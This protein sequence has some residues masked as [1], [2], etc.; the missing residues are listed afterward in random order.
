M[1][2]RAFRPSTLSERKEFYEKEFDIERL[3]KWFFENGMKLPQICALDAGSESGIIINKKLK[4]QML[5]F[6]FSELKIKI[7]KY[8][9]EDVYYDRNMYAD[10]EKVLKSLKFKGYLLQELVF[11]VD[12]E[13]I[14]CDCGEGNVCDQCLERAFNAAQKM[15]EELGKEFNS[16]TIVYSGR[17]FH[18]HVLDARAF[19]FSAQERRKWSQRFSKYPIDSW[20]SDGGISLIRISFS[21]NGL[22]SRRVLPLGKNWRSERKKTLPL[23][24]PY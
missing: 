14:A 17:G 10:S 2:K 21:L 1:I 12:A 24:L 7:K 18:V 20:V 23:F 16:I 4:G 11:D 6:P 3:R 22:V 19:A 5:Y 15:K 13:N 9:P 8:I